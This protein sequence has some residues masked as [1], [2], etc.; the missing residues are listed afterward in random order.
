MGPVGNVLQDTQD[1]LAEEK[2]Q[3]RVTLFHQRPPRT[4]KNTPSE[5]EP[6]AFI[7]KVPVSRIIVP[8]CSFKPQN[9]KIYRKDYEDY[10]TPT[11]QTKIIYSKPTLFTRPIYP[12]KAAWH[13]LPSLVWVKPNKSKLHKV[14]TLG[15]KNIAKQDSTST[16]FYPYKAF[17]HALPDMGWVNPRKR[18]WLKARVLTNDSVPTASEIG[19]FLDSPT[20]I[21]THKISSAI[22]PIR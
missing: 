2:S 9:D 20:K 4:K 5:K 13:T 10:Q 12:F 19:I 17:W 14:P 16:S 8:V 18:H 7:S 6:P 21:D 1:L 11:E 3:L 15:E 22:T